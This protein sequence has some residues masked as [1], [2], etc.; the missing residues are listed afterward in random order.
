M[1]WG[2]S[3]VGYGDPGMV[4]AVLSETVGVREAGAEGAEEVKDV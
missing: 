3:S 1:L 4:M 2:S